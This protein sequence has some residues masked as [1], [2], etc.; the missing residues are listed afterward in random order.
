MY[1]NLGNL[2]N[3]LGKFMK[4][5]HLKNKVLYWDHA[6]PAPPAPRENDMN[7]I[8]HSSSKSSNILFVSFFAVLIAGAIILLMFH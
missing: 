2:C 7:I 5:L 4:H 8:D 3:L 6:S 1:P